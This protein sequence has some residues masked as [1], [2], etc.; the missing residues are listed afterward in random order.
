MFSYRRVTPRSSASVLIY[1]DSSFKDNRKPMTRH[2]V[3]D[4]VDVV[5]LP[6]CSRIMASSI[7]V[8]WF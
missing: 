7:H 6:Q 3:Q 2:N 8:I 1:K 4:T 5:C